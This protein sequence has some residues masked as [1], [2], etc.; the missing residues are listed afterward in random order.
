MRERGRARERERE[1]ELVRRVDG[2]HASTAAAE[3]VHTRRPGARLVRARAQ[4][5]RRVRER[6]CVCVCQKSDNH[7]EV[8]HPGGATSPVPVRSYRTYEVLTREFPEEK[9]RQRT[10]SEP[11][12]FAMSICNKRIVLVIFVYI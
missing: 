8:L 6:E 11:R 1:R 12:R 5:A 3:S 4:Q 2:A 9:T 7:R 10:D